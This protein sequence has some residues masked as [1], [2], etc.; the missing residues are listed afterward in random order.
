MLEE[1]AYYDLFSMQVMREAMGASQ[2][3]F[4]IDVH[5]FLNWQELDLMGRGD[6]LDHRWESFLGHKVDTH[7]KEIWTQNGQS[8]LTPFT[9]NHAQELKP[10]T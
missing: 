9:C 10:T 1:L 7:L 8:T 2:E 5:K 3:H 4:D 6:N